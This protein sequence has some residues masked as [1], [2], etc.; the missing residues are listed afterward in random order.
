MLFKR[1]FDNECAAVSGMKDAIKR[2]STH[3]EHLWNHKKFSA[4]CKKI[5]SLFVESPVVQSR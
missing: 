5:P 3:L 1:H 2:L 4:I